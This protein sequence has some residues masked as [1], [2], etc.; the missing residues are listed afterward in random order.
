MKCFLKVLYMSI[1]KGQDTLGM[2]VLSKYI[3]DVVED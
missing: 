2:H 3:V 1:G